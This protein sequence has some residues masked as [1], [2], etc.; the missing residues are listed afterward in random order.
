MKLQ[1]GDQVIVTAGKDKGKKGVIAQVL[2][3]VNKVV[4]E[5]INLYVKHIKPMGER[6]GER[7]SMPRPMPSA[8][9]AI[10]NDKGQPDRVGYKVLK[11][12]QKVRIYKKTGA[13]IAA[14]KD[15]KTKSSK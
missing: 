2:P 8:K 6:S 10:L 3:K 5:G 1:R 13:E 15:T 11:T 4:I 9:V 12:G 14:P 7:R